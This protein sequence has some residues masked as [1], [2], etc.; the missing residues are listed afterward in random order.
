MAITRYLKIG[1]ESEYA[2][3]ATSYPDALDPETVDL[4]SED[5]DKLIYEGISGL[6]RVAGLGVY[7]TA[8]SITVP[9]DDK[10]APWFWKWTLGGYEVT[11]D[12]TTSF[13]HIFSPV[14][15][16]TLTSFSAKVGKDIMEHIF[17][18]N[19]IESLELEV[20]SEWALMTVNTLGAKD[21]KGTL[22]DQVDFNEGNIFTAPM[23][24]LSKDGS[25]ISPQIRSMTFSLET[26]A[27]IESSQGFGSR[28]PT[29]AF[30]GSM[31][32]SAELTLS[33]ENVDQLI[34]FWG[35]QDAPSEDTIQETSYTINFGDS[36]DISMP[37]VVYTASNQPVEGR[38]SVEQ[39]V[40]A[41]ALYDDTN[42]EGPVVVSVTNDKD[43]YSV[44]TG[45]TT[46]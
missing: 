45:G 27:D 1:E 16:G 28:F 33:F 17:L 32:A 5:D 13:T 30:S 18:G 9:L 37:R 41:R 15:G 39:T 46:T 10:I 6:D 4:D 42:K 38:D 24:S 7:S 12:S 19:V 20:E 44:S 8:G 21:K 26:G 14:T 25:D 23:V 29:Q 11:G 22:S 35:D 43:S 34:T 3:E 36:F 40:T 31:V 2:V